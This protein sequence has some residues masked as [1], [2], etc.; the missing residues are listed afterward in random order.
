MLQ[1][2][3]VWCYLN[4]VWT[5]CYAVLC[6]VLTVLEMV[7][8]AKWEANVGGGRG[9]EKTVKLVTYSPLLVQVAGRER[10]RTEHQTV[11]VRLKSLK[12]EYIFN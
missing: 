5:L 7:R 9:R 10:V 11:L 4:A 3:A 12:S 2:G 8:G 1:P 6:C